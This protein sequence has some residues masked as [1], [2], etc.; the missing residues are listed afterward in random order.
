RPPAAPLGP[1]APVSVHRIEPGDRPGRR[2]GERRDQTEHHRDEEGRRKEAG[3]ASRTARKGQPGGEQGEGRQAQTAGET[4]EQ[5][6][7][8]GHR[9]NQARDLTTV[10]IWDWS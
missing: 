9:N 6:L 4:H 8:G 3:A 7:E 5:L 1:V 2:N 10:A